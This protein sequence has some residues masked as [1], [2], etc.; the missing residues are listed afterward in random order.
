[1]STQ[2]MFLKPLAPGDVVDIVAPA[3]GTKSL[4]LKEAAQFLKSLGLKGR[5]PKGLLAPHPYL[6]NSDERR[7]EYLKKALLASDSKAVWCLRGGYGSLRLMDRLQKLKKPK[8]AKIFL[9]Y[10][11]ITTLHGFL[12]QAWEWPTLHG[13]VVDRFAKKENRKSELVSLKKILLGQ[14]Q[15]VLFSNLTALNSSAQKRRTIHGEVVGGNATVIQSMLATPWQMDLAGKILFLEDTGEKAYR[16]DRILNHLRQSGFL[17]NAKAVVFGG[18]IHSDLKEQRLIWKTTIPDF[19][20]RLTI[21]VLSGL[22]CGH[23][24]VQMTLP[25]NTQA[26]LNLGKS[27]RLLVSTGIESR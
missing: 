14:K 12:N 15:E 27:P 17:A 18:V 8:V 16:M 5:Y 4:R 22:P 24:K 9:G 10:S 21:P 25:F 3:S 26:A 1:M 19:A 23:G 11:D 2:E 13:P 6:A 7:F 20:S